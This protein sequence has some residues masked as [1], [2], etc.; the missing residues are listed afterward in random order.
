[1]ETDS[2]RDA[3]GQL[4][5]M[6]QKMLVWLRETLADA[7][8][9][10]LAVYLI[11]HQPMSTKNG[12]NQFEKGYH[13]DYLKEIMAEYKD[14]IRIGLFGDRNVAG[15]EPL[16]DRTNT[17][18]TIPMITVPG[19]SPRGMNFPALHAVVYKAD[20]KVVQDIFQYSLDIIDENAK[21]QAMIKRNE[22]GVDEYLGEW[23]LGRSKSW[24]EFSHGQP[25]TAETLVDATREIS[26][27]A[28]LLVAQAKWKRAGYVGSESPE[29]Y[30]CSILN[31]RSADFKNCLFARQDDRCWTDRWEVNY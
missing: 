20:T 8:N 6:R 25:L 30:L 27:S 14:I 7:Q 24:K 28:E 3:A 16:W 13:V 26:T 15:M 23:T 5:L 31:D 12:Y 17:V 1:V 19:V 10:N 9:K 21:V 18:P 22:S 29:Q 4:T 11:G 2:G